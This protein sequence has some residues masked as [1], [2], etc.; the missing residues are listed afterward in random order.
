MRSSPSRSAVPGAISAR[1]AR[2]G[3]PALPVDPGH[4]HAD[5]AGGRAHGAGAGMGR[6]AGGL[7]ASRSIGTAQS[8]DCHA[9]GAVV[10]TVMCHDAVLA[11]RAARRCRPVRR[12][13]ATLG[14]SADAGRRCSAERTSVTSITRMCPGR[15]RCSPGR[16]R[17]APAR[18]GSPS[19]AASASRRG[20]APT[21]RTSPVSPTS[22]IATRSRRERQVEPAG[23]DRQRDAEVGRRL[24]H[25][26]A[27]DGGG[28]DL[29]VVQGQPLGAALQHRQHHR[30]PGAVEPADGAP[31]RAGDGRADQR[32]H[33]GDQR[34]AALHRHRDAGA[35][36][37]APRS[38]S[39]TARTGRPGC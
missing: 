26:D 18:T 4:A 1:L 29:P 15:R 36:A 28:E 9:V 6:R 32:L 21:R 34:P 16:S 38:G 25:P 37:P 35:R 11:R 2:S 39:G 12:S 30:Q 23:G 7:A 20:T 27:A 14:H 13:S 10:V 24:D 19:R 5:R 17:A 8:T 22:P 31:G 33:L 3:S